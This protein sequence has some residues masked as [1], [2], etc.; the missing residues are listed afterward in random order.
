MAQDA[1]FT[2]LKSF[3]PLLPYIPKTKNLI[4]EPACGDGRLI[5]EMLKFGIPAD[6][7]DLKNG[8]DFL[9]D[10]S[11]R[12]VIITNPPFSLA[13]EFIKHA[14]DHCN[15]VFL[16]LRLNFLGAKCRKKFWEKYKP[17]ALFILSERPNFVMSV[18][19]KSG[20]A[21]IRGLSQETDICDYKE[22]MPIDSPRP[23][24]CPKCGGKVSIGSSDSTEYCWMNWSKTCN[25]KGLYWL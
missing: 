6:G 17:D 2:P 12:E 3:L 15:E 16:L 23:K 14:V 10:N 19:C 5:R 13:Q 11:R 4:W 20:R 21:I 7:N 9:Q 8:Y 18:K 1:Y 25:H 24:C 22:L